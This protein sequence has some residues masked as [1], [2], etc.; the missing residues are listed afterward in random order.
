MYFKVACYFCGRKGT[1]KS[2]FLQRIFYNFDKLSKIKD[3]R[4]KIR[5]FPKYFA[6]KS[7]TVGWILC[8]IV[9]LESARRACPARWKSCPDGDIFLKKAR[10]QVLRV[11]R[12]LWLFRRIS[13]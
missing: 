5:D 9:R 10:I 4:Y 7:N 2:V 13:G 6:A 1:K 8:L 3:K 12:A 11:W